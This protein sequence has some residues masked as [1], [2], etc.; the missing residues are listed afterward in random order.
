[1]PGYELIGTE[2]LDEIKHLFN[3][4]GI[5]FR[6]GFDNL[7]NDI[8]KVRDFEN[9]FGQFSA[10]VLGIT[11]IGMLSLLLADGSK[12]TYDVKEVKFI[13]WFKYRI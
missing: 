10:T 9:E 13:Y 7:R 1:M 11:E 2:E 3:N 5:L 6:H 12:K 4:S 8:Y